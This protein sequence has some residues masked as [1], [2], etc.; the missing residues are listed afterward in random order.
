VA[1]VRYHPVAVSNLTKTLSYV[2]FEAI[3][4]NL[5]QKPLPKAI[6]L[7]SPSYLEAVNALLKRTPKETIQAYLLWVTIRTFISHTDSKT[8]KSYEDFS[9]TLAGIDPNVKKERW[10][11]CVREMDE[12]LGFLAG[13]FYVRKTF[14]GSAKE[15]GRMVIEQIKDAFIDRFAELDWVDKETREVAVRKVKNLRVKV[16][17]NDASPNMTDPMDLAKY[18]F[19]D[20]G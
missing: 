7:T 12:T 8:R 18:F 15:R 6:L 17:Y 2:D 3:V 5:T 20:K 11:T 13:E 9:K 1:H 19:H 4:E 14:G 10:K 16:G